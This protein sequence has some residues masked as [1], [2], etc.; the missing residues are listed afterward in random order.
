MLINTA[1]LGQVD[2]DPNNIFHLPGGLYGFERAS[3]YALITKQDEDFTLMLFQSVE[4]LAPCFVVFNPYDIFEDYTPAMEAGDL[5]ALG[6]SGVDELSFFVIAVV[7]EDVHEI[8]VNLKSP[9]AVNRKKKM[10]RQVI[11]SNTDYPIK[12]PLF[13]DEQEK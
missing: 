7:P 11:L 3:D 1:V 12:Y 2:V 8:S 10:A 5:K 9:I 6:V 4:G 13:G